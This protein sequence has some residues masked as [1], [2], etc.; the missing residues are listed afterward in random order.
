MSEIAA[1]AG[2]N[3]TIAFRLVHTLLKRGFIRAA[4]PREYQSNVRL[5]SRKRFRIGYASQTENS[6]FSAAVTLGLHN[7]AQNED[8]DLLVLDNRYSPKTALKNAERMIAERVDLAIE[9]QTFEKVA[10]VIAS[11]FHEAGIPLIA[12]EIPHPGATFYGVENYRVGLLGGRVLGN[13]AKQHWGGEIDEL[14]LMELQAA[15]P[16]PQLRVSGIEAA[17]RENLPRGSQCVFTHLDSKGEF[18]QA[19]ELVRRHT[20]RQAPRRTLIAGV[21]DQSVLGAIRAFEEAGRGAL[22]AGLGLGAIPEARSELVKPASRLI[23]SI[24]FFPEQYGAALIKLALDI[25]HKR[26]VPPAVY[27]HHQ[28]ITAANVRK[29]YPQYA[30]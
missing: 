22:C 15:G 26:H 20:R 16:L 28:L 12:V 1:R 5:A 30:V 3:R 8:I 14:L 24:A 21:N 18:D 6:P 23:G 7:A 13:W 11:M 29:F 9:F 10:P 19:L 2:L 17:I 27:A 25:L 4:G